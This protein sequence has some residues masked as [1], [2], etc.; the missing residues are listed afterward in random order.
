MTEKKE[1]K[2]S[3]TRGTAKVKA[4]ATK[5]S[6]KKAQK[7]AKKSP[8]LQAKEMVNYA[9]KNNDWQ[10]NLDPKSANRPLEVLST[11]S[12]IV[13][14]L[15]GGK[16][17]D[18]G[19]APCP[20]IPR[21][22]IANVY[23]REGSGKTTLA[24]ETSAQ[25]IRDGGVV[26]YIDWEHEI[27]PGYAMALGVPIG[28]EERF[29]LCQPDTLDEGVAILW[30]M[31]NS[32]VDLVVLD[33]VGAG[34]PKAYFEKSI[35]ETAQQG[36][37]G[38]NAAVWSAFLPKLKARTS[39]TGSAIMGISQIRDAINTTGGYGDTFTV[40]GG[41]AWKFYSAL[42]LRLQPMGVEKASD[43][44]ALSNKA[45][46]RVIGAKI[47][48]KL[49]KCKVS[50]Q[51]GN[52]EI[53]YIRWGEGIDDLRSLIEI[54]RAHRLVQAKGTWFYWVDPEGQQHGKQGMENFRKLFVDDPRLASM[55]EKQVKP[56][57]GATG[58]SKDEGG[59]GDEEEELFVADVF[60]NDGEL[61][62]ILS[63]IQEEGSSEKPSDETV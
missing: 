34:V 46:D 49:D 18:R 57:M 27:V 58:T 44:S 9:L 20:G 62:E 14:H 7:G 47:K 52:E 15:I 43:Y 48:A 25:T 26:C 37:V 2:K 23:G 55:L 54:G 28:D 45:Q 29:M 6:A 8:L 63:N 60:Q 61:R 59:E 10:A 4:K 50:P 56:Y 35:K 51:Q 1:S 41:H 16:P 5:K 19:V 31:V 53:F 33:S 38:M 21:G 24:L 32:G 12:I 30:T 22:R 39:K 11:S 40:Q 36:R 3:M 17:N 13:D 42:R